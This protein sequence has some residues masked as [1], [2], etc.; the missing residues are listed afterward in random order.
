MDKRIL[1]T[2]EAA[3][4]CGLAASTLERLRAVGVGPRF[5]RLSERALGYDVAALDQWLDQRASEAERR[6]KQ[7]GSQG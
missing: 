6:G 2:P 3:A 5:V 4:Y 7:S 1:R